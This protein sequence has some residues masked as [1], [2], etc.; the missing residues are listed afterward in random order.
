[1]FEWAAAETARFAIQHCAQPVSDSVIVRPTP[2]RGW[3]SLEPLLHVAVDTILTAQVGSEENWERLVHAQPIHNTMGP[4]WLS[5]FILQR[6]SE[7]RIGQALLLYGDAARQ[8]AARDRHFSLTGFEAA[9]HRALGADLSAFLATL[10]Q[11]RRPE[12]STTLLAPPH[13]SRYDDLVLTSQHG[14]LVLP[15]AYTSLFRKLSETPIEMVRWSEKQ[16]AHRA[17]IAQSDGA[18]RGPTRCCDTP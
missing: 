11:T 6:R 7:F 18:V 17:G 5:Q 3:Q 15:N 2:F 13:E 12:L 16:S 10:L 8:R 14:G 9:L 1:M 4:I